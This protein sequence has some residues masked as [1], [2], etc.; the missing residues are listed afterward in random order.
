MVF[1]IG[2][3]L[4]LCL[5][6]IAYSALLWLFPMIALFW[7]GFRFFPAFLRFLGELWRGLWETPKSETSKE[8]PEFEEHPLFSMNKDRDPPAED[9]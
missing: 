7:G 6:C 3:F 1:L 4:A 9:R 8:E 5:S 2:I